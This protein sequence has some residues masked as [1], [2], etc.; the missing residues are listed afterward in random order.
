ME[1]GFNAQN[2]H[3]EFF[4]KH[5]PCF[6][7]SNSPPEKQGPLVCNPIFTI[8]SVIFIG[9]LVQVTTNAHYQCLRLGGLS[10]DDG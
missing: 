2:Y 5:S 10:T 6:I 1:V 7:S 3:S 4:F 8:L 9:G